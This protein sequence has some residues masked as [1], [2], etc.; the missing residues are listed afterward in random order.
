MNTKLLSIF[1]ACFSLT[2]NAQ[3]YMYGTTSEG[4][5]N[6]L[7][8]IYRVDQNGQNIQKLFDFTATTGGKPTAGLTL[9]DNGKLYGFTNSEGQIVNPGARYS[10]GSFYEFDPLTNDLQVIQYFDDLSPTGVSYEH[11]PLLHTNGLLYTTSEVGEK[12][13]D[14]GK[15]W[16]YDVNTGTISILATLD[17]FIYGPNK[18]KLMEASDTNIYFTTASGSKNGYGAIVRFNTSSNSLEVVYGSPGGYPKDEQFQGASNNPLFE[19]SDG[20]LY[21]AS[22]LG[23]GNN[24]GNLFKIDKNGNNY[25]DVFNFEWIV[26]GEGW[27]PQGGFI[28]KNGFLYSATAQHDQ[29]DINS[30]TFYKVELATGNLTFTNFLDFEGY[31]PIGT[32]IESSNGRFYITC[33][34]GTINDGSIVEYNPLNGKITQRHDF[35]IGNNGANPL[36]NSLCLVD[37][38]ALSIDDSSL[39]DNGVKTYPNPFQDIVNIKVE[40]SYQI[41]TI[42]ILDLKGSE[43]YMDESKTKE[44]FINTS[45]L[46]S[47]VYLLYIKTDNGSTTRKIIKE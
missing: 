36:R 8:T 5:A 4:G 13:I 45:F 28:E 1:I 7:G 15:I 25:Q 30:G 29:Q 6:G 26:A 33:S 17:A 39:L 47:G 42:K 37:F 35:N 19:A 46:S 23:G 24:K 12:L 27:D 10:A 2:A 18:S 43:L 22:K 20:Y 38:S 21:G 14:D 3:K 41:E 31:R 9:A 34:G 44:S 32:F 40:E 16:S 11:S